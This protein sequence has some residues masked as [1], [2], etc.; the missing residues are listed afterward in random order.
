VIVT[1]NSAPATSK[2]GHHALIGTAGWAIPRAVADGFPPQGSSLERYA[3]I[4]P[5]AEINS[6][7]HKPHRPATYER[8]AASVPEQFRFAVKLP[9]EISH[10]RKLVDFA[11][12]LAAFIDEV[13]G[14]GDK[15]AA[16]LLQLPP[17]AVFDPR[18]A[19]P[20][21]ETLR[22][23]FGDARD[24]VCEPRSTSWFSDEANTCLERYRIARVIADPLIGPEG[25]QPSGWRDI[26]YRRLHGSP[27]VY[28]S[29]YKR[30]WLERLAERIAAELRDGIRSWCMFD[31][32]ASG[33]A[34]NDALVL[35]RLLAELG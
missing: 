8:W 28:Y 4:M 19:D 31:N 12:P 33:A 35:L 32:T 6:S 22:R 20:I 27:R 13:R 25:Q 2:T 26:R 21:F 14:L 16:L 30:E 15:L 17:S 1:E 34:M 18:L 11:D 9:K 10:K 3:A 24:I 7:F 5:A 23:A 29:A